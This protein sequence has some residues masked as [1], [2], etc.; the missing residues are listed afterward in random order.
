M[1][2]AEVKEEEMSFQ[3][4]LPWPVVNSTR[5]VIPATGVGVRN[6]QAS[7]CIYKA[8]PEKDISSS[9]RREGASLQLVL[10]VTCSVHRHPE[11]RYVSHVCI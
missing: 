6:T 11:S 3:N 1:E 8:T 5:C 7:F 9:P 2:E 10:H 4:L